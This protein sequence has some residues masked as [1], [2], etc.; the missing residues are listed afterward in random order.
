MIGAV[1]VM[2]KTVA[3]LLMVILMSLITVNPSAKET[4]SDTFGDIDASSGITSVDALLALQYSV[5]KITLNES[6]QKYADVNVDGKVNANDALL[7][8][9]Y[10]VQKISKLPTADTVPYDLLIEKPKSQLDNGA[11]ARDVSADCSFKIDTTG[12]ADNTIYVLTA[13]AYR[14]ANNFVT[15][16]CAR[17]VFSLQGLINRDYGI[18]HTSL[19]YCQV[20]SVNRYWYDYLT[21]EDGSFEGYNVVNITTFDAFVETFKAQIEH[22]GIILWDPNVPSTANVAATICGLDGYLPVKHDTDPRSFYSKLLDYNNNGYDI[23]TKQTLAGLFTGEGTIPDTDIASSGSTKCDAYLWAVEKYMSRC[24]TKYIA[25]IV[26][27]AVAVSG[28]PIAAYGDAS[29]PYTTCLYNHDYLIARRCFFFDLTPYPGEAPCDDK[30][31]PVGTDSQTLIK[32][33]NARYKRANGEFG[34]MLGFPP[35]WLKYTNHNNLGGVL[36]VHLEWMCVEFASSF[37]LAKEADAAHPCS[38]ANGSVYYKYVSRTEEFVN[39][40]PTD[41]TKYDKNTYYYTIY[42]GDYDSSAWLAT[43]ISNFWGSD[44]KRGQIPMFWCFNPN[45]SDRVPMVF[46]YVYKTATPNDFFGAGDSGAGYVIPSALFEGHVVNTRTAKSLTRTKPDAGKKWAEYSKRYYDIFDMDITGFLL[47]VGYALDK[48]VLDTFNSISP[49]GSLQHYWDAQKL[50][51]HNGTYYAIVFNCIGFTAQQD[52]LAAMQMYNDA[53][54]NMNGRHFAAYRT[55]CKSPAE[56][57]NLVNTYAE[58]AASKN[59]T[60]KYV[61]PY[62]YF[63]LIKESGEANSSSTFLK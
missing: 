23:K 63:R 25:Y 59:V 29:S 1:A 62:T 40:E 10:S 5:S 57:Y 60:V 6:Q 36:D 26:D 31:Q 32:I 44:E 22:C 13:G 42:L 30:D 24:S 56:T 49:A 15:K 12:L 8:L 43:H 46:D 3:I 27:G 38:L 47:N 34:Q 2:K 28:N 61:D 18:T 51:E 4:V 58:Y 54:G 35:W 19:V 16:D 53:L 14:M 39:T 17:F 21:G 20:E 7:I 33:F 48:K 9:Q 45:L 41:N 52:N 11:Y 37:N 50:F 55:I